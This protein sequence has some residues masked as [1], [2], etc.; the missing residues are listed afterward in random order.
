QEPCIGKGL[1]CARE[2]QNAEIK[3][4]LQRKGHAQSGRIGLDFDFD[5]AE[6]SSCS[7]GRD[8]ILYIGGGEWLTRS[9]LHE[10]SQGFNRNFRIDDQV[11][12][13]NL[14]AF[15]G[16]LVVL[17][18]LLALDAGRPREDDEH[19]NHPPAHRS[20]ARGRAESEVVAWA[21]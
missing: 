19:R 9:L 13:R 2:V 16:T 10:H 4:W 14:S 7:Q 17:E 21:K 18:S 6:P 12:S 1:A 8:R 15:I 20:V 3:R 5:L 11:Y